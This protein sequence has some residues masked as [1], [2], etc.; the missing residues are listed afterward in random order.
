MSH[1]FFVCSVPDTVM[2]IQH[3]KTALNAAVIG[4]EISEKKADDNGTLICT[5]GARRLR[6]L[7]E[8]Q[9]EARRRHRP[10]EHQCTGRP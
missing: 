1:R 9:L 2:D 10:D 8:C 7:T 5:R 4:I 6:S 3:I